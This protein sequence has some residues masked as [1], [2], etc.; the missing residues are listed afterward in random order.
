VACR[1]RRASGEGRNMREEGGEVKRHGGCGLLS[2]SLCLRGLQGWGDECLHACNLLKNSPRSGT[3]DRSPVVRLC[4]VPCFSPLSLLCGVC[5]AFPRPL[6]SPLSAHPPSALRQEP[7]TYP[8]LHTGPKTALHASCTL[9]FAS[10][11]GRS[12]HYYSPP[13][14][15]PHRR[16]VLSFQSMLGGR[17]LS[18]LP[19]YRR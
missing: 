7:P 13:T 19:L 5:H 14:L 10:L 18:P 11:P 3:H 8:L 12:P 4:L 17:E 2:S 1:Q 15:C 16:G 9:L 6:S